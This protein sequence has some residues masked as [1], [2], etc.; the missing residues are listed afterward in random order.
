MWDAKVVESPT[1]D[2]VWKVEYTD[3]GVV[4]AVDKKD[5]VVYALGAQEWGSREWYGL[6][7]LVVSVRSSRQLLGSASE[8]LV[9]GGMRQA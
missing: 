9:R 7:Y 4:M 2:G 6:R 5:L 3:G 8:F 1:K